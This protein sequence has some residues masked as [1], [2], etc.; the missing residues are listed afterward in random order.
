MGQNKQK[1]KGEPRGPI[2]RESESEIT[3]QCF[4]GIRLPINNNTDPQTCG[5]DECISLANQF[6]T[7]LNWLRQAS[8]ISID[9]SLVNEQAEKKVLNFLEPIF[10]ASQK[11]IAY[12]T[13]LAISTVSS[14]L[15]RLERRT[16]VRKDVFHDAQG[17]VVS[18]KPGKQS[19]LWR[20][21]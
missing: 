7:V 17:N 3:H 13:G 20:I 18:R 21:F 15:S 19:I 11:V 5:S 8:F 14:A 12:E 16:L 9:T 2:I 1:K 4:C 6:G 10:G